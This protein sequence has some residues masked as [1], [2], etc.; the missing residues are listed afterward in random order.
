MHALPLMMTPLTTISL[1]PTTQYRK[2]I[3]TLTDAYGDLSEEYM[4]LATQVYVSNTVIHSTTYSDSMVPVALARDLVTGVH[5]STAPYDV[6]KL[7]NAVLSS[8]EGG[9]RPSQ[10]RMTI[11]EPRW[12]GAARSPPQQM[13]IFSNT[14]GSPPHQV[15][16]SIKMLGSLHLLFTFVA[17]TIWVSGFISFLFR[18]F[19]LAVE[20]TETGVLVSGR[21]ICP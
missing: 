7:K 3:N 15:S 16:S 19:V 20:V 17:L 1:L 18:R 21:C 9:P 14:I 12:C 6:G 10:T 8:D 13:M 2:T 11:D 5:G 4:K